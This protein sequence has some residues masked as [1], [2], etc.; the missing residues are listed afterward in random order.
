MPKRFVAG[1]NLG[2]FANLTGRGRSSAGRGKARGKSR[3]GKP[4]AC[5]ESLEGRTLLSHS[6]IV[7]P[8]GND[9]SSGTVQAPF[10]TIQRAANV[11][12]WGDAVLI[13]GGTY[14]E[15]VNVNHGGITFEA[16]NGENVTVSAADAVGGWTQYSGNIWRSRVPVNLGEGNNQVFVDGRMINEA[17]W[18]NTSLDVSHPNLESAPSIA[19]GGGRATIYDPRLSAGWAGADIHIASGEGWY[20]QTGIVSASGNGWLTFN[21]QQ[22][23][24]VLSPRSGNG[25]YLYG[26]FQA[27]DSP[28][29]FYVDNGG[30]LYVWAPG[31][32]NPYAHTIE[33]KSRQFAFNLFGAPNI[34]LEGINIFG[35]TVATNVYSSHFVM[36]HVNASY[37]SHFM[38]QS[39][40]WNQPWDTGIELNGANS[41]VEN[42]TIAYSAGDG[43]YVNSANDTIANNVIHDTDYNA[44]DS[45]PVRIYGNGALVQHNVIYNAGRCGVATHAYATRIIGNVIHDVMLQ[46]ADGGGIY[47]IRGNGG[48]S[49]FASNQIY[50]IHDYVYSPHPTWYTA[51]GIFLDDYS[52]GFTIDNNT[53]WNTDAAVKLN[54]SSR[55]N[56]LYANQLSGNYASVTGNSR[57]D[58]AGTVITNNTLYAPI[59][60]QGSGAAIYAN[61]YSRGSPVPPPIPSLPVPISTPTPAPT[62]APPSSG[63]SPSGS[64]GSGSSSSGPAYSARNTWTAVNC[65]DSH[66]MLM[67]GG[68]IGGNNGAWAEYHNLDFGAGASTFQASLAVPAA[69]AGQ[70]IQI[71]IDGANGPVIGTLVTKSTGS[72]WTYALE[73]ATIT[74][75]TGVHDVFL[76]YAGSYGIGDINTFRFA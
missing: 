24:S 8:W 10:R 48:A 68:V 19:G 46:T 54:Y 67:S 11:A 21:Y 52:S 65:F 42:S 37:I 4:S 59:Q 25:Y 69:Y 22:D 13:R 51:N 58:W 50:N 47:T 74:H 31:N 61:R 14:R 3:A 40:G 43:V 12:T 16:Y 23:S 29:E 26:K 41:V 64:S 53:I 55:N 62:P 70:Q 2:L 75:V 5:V 1:T 7:A 34:T 18:P 49:E 17:R 60:Q 39:I 73:S 27:L 57:G 44:G 63:G 66:A 45:S 35:G 71:R 36:D 72:W 20:A 9:G 15:T 32:S 28:G 30:Y 76:V 38:W 56:R 33:A 6:W